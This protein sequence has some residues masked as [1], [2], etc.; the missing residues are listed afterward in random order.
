MIMKLN[1]YDNKKIIKIKIIGESRRYWHKSP[2]YFS[3]NYLLN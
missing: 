1:K 3:L 2:L